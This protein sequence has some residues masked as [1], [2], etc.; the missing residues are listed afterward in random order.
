MV[1]KN[2]TSKIHNAPEL[3]LCENLIKTTQQQCREVHLDGLQRSYL[4]NTKM[5]LF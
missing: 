1:K 4:S 5:F 3:V 2:L